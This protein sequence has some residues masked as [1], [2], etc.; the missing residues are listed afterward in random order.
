MLTIAGRPTVQLA[1]ER[2][3]RT[4]RPRVIAGRA[5]RGVVAGCPT[6]QASCATILNAG[7]GARWWRRFRR[8]TPLQAAAGREVGHI[9][10]DPAHDRAPD[11][12][13][14]QGRSLRRRR[15]AARC[16]WS[17]LLMPAELRHCAPPGGQASAP[18]LGWRLCR[19]NPSRSMTG[20]P[21]LLPF[22]WPTRG[23]RGPTRE[24]AKV[25]ATAL[26]PLRPLRLGSI[27]A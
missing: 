9:G 4:I 14:G 7:G 22:V 5:R 8:R 10:A 12:G 18:Q 24:R 26:A 25:P 23:R 1:R 6:G 13:V 11:L 2:Q 19:P 16:R 27:R 3:C 20:Q 15:W 21:V 17:Q